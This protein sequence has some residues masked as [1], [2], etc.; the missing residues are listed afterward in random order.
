MVGAGPLVSCV[1]CAGSHNPP[2]PRALLQQ[3][4]T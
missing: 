2:Y 4:V 1:W 3:T